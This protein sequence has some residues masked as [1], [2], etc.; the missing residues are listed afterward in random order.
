[1]RHSSLLTVAGSLVL[2]VAATPA[3]SQPVQFESPPLPSVPSRILPPVSEAQPSL[4]VVSRPRA[5]RFATPGKLYPGRAVAIHFQTGDE[6]ISFVQL[7]D[8]TEIVYETN[9]ALETGQARAIFLRMVQPF[10]FEGQTQS[11]VP[12]LMVTTTD[13]SGRLRTYVFNLYP[14]YGQM[15]GEADA[16]GIA[17]VPTDVAEAER[18]ARVRRG[19]G[20][21]GATVANTVVTAL[22][23]ASAADIQLGLD[24][25]IARGY[26]TSTDPVTLKVEEL[27][28]ETRN[29]AD[30]FDTM[31]RLELRLPVVAALGQLGIERRN[32][33]RQPLLEV[34]PGDPLPPD[35][36]PPQPEDVS[37]AGEGDRE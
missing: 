17:I 15:P 22:G 24:I 18:V 4:A 34:E 7:S 31:D 35:A 27:V 37:N 10:A 5:S 20:L 9:A 12:T 30:I 21:T 19:S 8:L 23:P 29:G 11:S 25:A 3:R 26:T 16:N 1:M 32:E 28:L 13:T 2:A 6:A 14:Q 33:L 36:L